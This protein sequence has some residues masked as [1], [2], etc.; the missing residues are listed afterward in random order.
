MKNWS[1]GKLI[2]VFAGCFLLIII[3]AVVIMKA[4]SSPVKR[5]PTPS[6]QFQQ[7]EQKTQVDV[8]ALQLEAS[9]KDAKKALDAQVQSQQQVMIVR[10]EMRRNNQLMI[11]QFAQMNAQLNDMKQRVDSMDARRNTV[12]IIKPPRKVAT[13]SANEIMAHNSKAVPESSGY[14]VQATVGNRAWIKSGDRE[15]SVKPGEKL[16]PIQRDLRIK[17]IDN[18]SGIVI[19]GPAR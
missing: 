8:L 6:T 2:G 9:Q 10:D 16:P 17:A 5:V 15:E 7:P 11:N 13:P 3:I 12:E 1:F 18:E 19:T 14:K 4:S